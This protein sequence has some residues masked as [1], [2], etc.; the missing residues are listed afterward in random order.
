MEN[1]EQT[2]GSDNPENGGSK[3]SEKAVPF[4]QYSKL[5]AEIENLK[6]TNARILEEH[7]QAKQ[8]LKKYQSEKE[9]IEQEHLKKAGKFEDLYHQSQEKIDQ[10][11]SRYTSLEKQVLEK[12]LRAQMLTHANDIGVDFDLFKAALNKFEGV[13]SDPETMSW[14]GVK[15]A[16]EEMREKMPN[17]FVP[18]ETAPQF[19]KRP[20]GNQTEVDKE[21]AFRSELAACKTTNEMDRVYRKYGKD[22][23]RPR[24]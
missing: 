17:L 10:W 13:K 18:R 21:E 1:Q 9:E 15:E 6:R 11:Q 12:D 22:E 19:G 8:R 23:G 4:E 7:G 20:S 14:K 3:G 24:F 2:G 5:E 16:V